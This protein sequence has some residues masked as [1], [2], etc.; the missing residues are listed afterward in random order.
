MQSWGTQDRFGTRFTEREPSKSGVIGLICAALGR[1]RHE[2]VTD[3]AALQM[4]VRV[5]A[6][7][8][9]QMDYH[10]AGGGPD[11]LGRTGVIKASGASGDTV[12]SRRYYLADADFLVGLSGDAE[13]LSTIETAL[14]RPVWALALGR[15]AFVPGVPV[16]LPGPGGLRPDQD[17]IGALRSEPWPRA[18]LPVPTSPPASLR[19]VLETPDGSGE[20]TKLD[21]PLGAA[22]QTRTFGPRRTTTL[23]LGI[24]QDVP[25]RRVD[26]HVPLTTGA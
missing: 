22:F 26:D 20:T 9:L 12:L 24:N 11:P 2:S 19:V 7:G 5:D 3:L 6:E 14:H 8:T 18:G 10:T 1:P 15:K 17:L 21:Q 4:G 25:L 13:L 23:Y 16:H